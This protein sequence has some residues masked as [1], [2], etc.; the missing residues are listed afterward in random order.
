MINRKKKKIQTCLG[1][2]SYLL[3][4]LIF[5]NLSADKIVRFDNQYFAISWQI[6]RGSFMQ[7]TTRSMQPSLLWSRCLS[8]ILWPRLCFNNAYVGSVFTG[9]KRCYPSAYGYVVSK[10]QV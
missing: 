9:R 8:K 10:N 7:M 4:S 5:K 6:I 1:F 3:L 2:S